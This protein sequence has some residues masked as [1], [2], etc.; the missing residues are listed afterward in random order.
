MLRLL[1]AHQ[2]LGLFSAQQ[3]TGGHRIPRGPLASL[4][5]DSVFS[6]PDAAG[7]HSQADSMDELETNLREVI[8]MLLK[9]SE[10]VLESEFVGLQTIRVA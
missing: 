3:Q 2:G 7:A 6:S 9:D 10:P 5:T 1:L 4:A 8:E